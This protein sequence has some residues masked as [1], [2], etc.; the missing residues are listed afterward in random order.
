[1]VLVSCTLITHGS[2]LH[3]CVLGGAYFSHIRS[4]TEHQLSLC[5]LPLCTFSWSSLRTAG[6]ILN[7][8]LCWRILLNFVQSFQVFWRQFYEHCTYHNCNL[9][10][11]Y[12]RERCF[13]QKLQR[14]MKDTFHFWS[15]P[16]YICLMVFE[17]IKSD[18]HFRTCIFSMDA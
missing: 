3:C 7:E 11:V 15:Y 6:C 9:L 8:I 5:H 13:E 14:K 10:S 17:I 2:T 1:M 12:W 4:P 18:V 16:F